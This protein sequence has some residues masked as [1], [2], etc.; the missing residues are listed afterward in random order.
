MTGFD[1][2]SAYNQQTLDICHYIERVCAL[3]NALSVATALCPE[4]LD[5][6][7]ARKLRSHLAA[8]LDADDRAAL[9]KADGK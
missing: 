2:K 7:Q 4:L 6:P 8:A 3:K 5:T 9:A 1:W